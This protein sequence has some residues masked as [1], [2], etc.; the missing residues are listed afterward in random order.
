[1][2]FLFVTALAKYESG[3]LLPIR[4]KKLNENEIH[5]YLISL[6]SISYTSMYYQILQVH[7]QVYNCNS[8]YV[9]N[10]V[11]IFITKAM[12]THVICLSFQVDSAI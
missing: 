1:M 5:S 4:P 12:S 10:D 8:I 6:I 9:C 2:F 7:P 3:G 11:G